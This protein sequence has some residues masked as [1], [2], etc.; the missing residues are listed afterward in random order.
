[1]IVLGRIVAP[2]GLQGWVKVHPFGDG[3]EAWPGMARWWLADKTEG[4]NW[5]EVKLVDAKVHGPGLIAKFDGFADRSAAEALEGFYIAAPRELLPKTADGEYY[6]GDLV[7]LKVENVQGVPFGSV[8]ELLETGANTVLVV[9][10][11][12]G[13]LKCERLLPFVAQV[14]KQVD[15]VAGRI[16]VD[17]DRDW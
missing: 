7:G 16:V 13:E 15:T 11:G 12:D 17:W 8:V 3:W 6:W 9:C 2:Y 10:D 1:M 5:R 4:A 14:V